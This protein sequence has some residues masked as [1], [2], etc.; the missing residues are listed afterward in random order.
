M[1]SIEDDITSTETFFQIYNVTISGNRVNH[2]TY[3]YVDLTKSLEIYLQ[4]KEDDNYFSDDGTEVPL[5]KTTSDKLVDSVKS[6][7]HESES[8]G[9]YGSLM[10]SSS[11]E[12]VT[13]HP[14]TE[15]PNHVAIKVRTK[16]SK[17]RSVLLW[18]NG[19]RRGIIYVI[20]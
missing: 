9:T 19:I 16:P 6:T 10:T 2:I 5:L 1:T 13:S 14:P 20:R 15:L 17:L 4:L 18:K 8:R 7:S 12:C 11:I 3:N